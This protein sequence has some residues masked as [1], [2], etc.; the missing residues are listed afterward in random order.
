LD[1]K[2]SAVAQ[3]GF[4]VFPMPLTKIVRSSD[5]FCPVF[6]HPEDVTNSGFAKSAEQATP[7]TRAAL[8]KDD[9]Q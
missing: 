5:F 9:A 2:K 4:R 1:P 8:T 7:I 6:A 3:L